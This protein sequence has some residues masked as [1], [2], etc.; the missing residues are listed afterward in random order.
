MTMRTRYRRR[1]KIFA[2]ALAMASVGALAAWALTL[3]SA[4]PEIERPVDAKFSKAEIQRGAS[5]AAVGDCAVCHTA[6]RG[7]P[8]AGGKALATPFGTLYATNIT[9]DAGTGIGS[10]SVEAFQ[11]AM[12][13]GVRR[14]GEHLYPALPY[15][16]FTKTSTTDLAALYAFL[17]T[18]EAV[19]SR[20]P[21]NELIPPLGFR[22]L[23]A[24]W[25]FLF[26]PQ[27]PY[28]PDA[29]KSAEWN[30][31][32]YLVE[33]LGHCG[34]CHTPRNALGAEKSHLA[35]TGGSA[36]GWIAPPL[37]GS[38]PSVSRWNA[39]S[40]FRYLRTGADARHGMAGGPMGPV[41]HALAGASEDDVKAIAVYID[42]AMHP[43][44]GTQPRLSPAAGA[45]IDHTESAA[46]E[47]PVGAIL[48]AG[49]CAGCHGDGAPMSRVGRAPLSLV[50]SV[51][52]GE[53]HN[54]V[55][56]ILQGL[57]TSTP[58]QRPFMP[59]FSDALSDAQVAAL[60]AYVRARFTDQPPWSDLER[61]VATARKEGTSP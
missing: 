53:P 43:A 45:L 57:R 6:E 4:M 8:F 41:S 60:A 24:G 42:A 28:I 2:G 11:R 37:D 47:Q 12:R 51:Q 15:E 26:L 16:H 25:K 48:F 35:L 32:G 33:S 46:R 23:L 13:E 50:T 27:T 61:S 55:M 59:G 38:N 36:E 34:G 30:R 3:R 19:A 5:L 14:N 40:L 21:P 17:M 29:T 7:K 18:R 10:W 52:A 44:G 20:P 56:A 58:E 9:P 1:A 49:A 54:T 31:G 39:D 22:P